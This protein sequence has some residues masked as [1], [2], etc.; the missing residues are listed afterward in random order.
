MGQNMHLLMG[1]RLA[2]GQDVNINGI[3][4]SRTFILHRDTYKQPIT[5][6]EQLNP[7]LSRWKYGTPG[8]RKDTY[9]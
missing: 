9:F 6:A 4:L 5:K 1:E 3:L 2:T 7:T 8:K